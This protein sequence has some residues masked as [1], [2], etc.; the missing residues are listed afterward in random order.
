MTEETTIPFILVKKFHRNLI[1]DMEYIAK[2][3]N[4]AE[5][6]SEEQRQESRAQAGLLFKEVKK[7]EEMIGEYYLKL[8]I[9]GN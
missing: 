4:T 2:V 1:D 5:G 7:L 6:L 3:A 9:Y 8:D